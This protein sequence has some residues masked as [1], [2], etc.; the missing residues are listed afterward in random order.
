MPER[1]AIRLAVLIE[2]TALG[3]AFYLL[4][5]EQFPALG[6]ALQ[7]AGYIG[8]QHAAHGLGKLAIEL[9]KSYRV[10]VAP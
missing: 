1:K 6:L 5:K 8:C 9:E 4:N 7:R 2:L 3:L 10:K